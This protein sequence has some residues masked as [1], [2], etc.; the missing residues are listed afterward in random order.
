[1]LFNLEEDHGTHIRCYLIPDAGGATPAIRLCSGGHALATVNADTIR[2][3]IIAS[4]RHATGLCGFII[5]EATVPGLAGFADLELRE[6]ETGLLVY[7]RPQP[8]FHRD[9]KVF[10]LETHL[11]P[12]RRFD[13]TL[14]NTFQ[15][16]YA[17]IDRRG[18]ETSMQTFMLANCP[19]LY[20]SGR[21]QFRA[22][23]VHLHAFTSLVMMRDPFNEL[24]ERLL[25]LQHLP[26]DGADL[27][28][29]RDLLTFK[30]TIDYLRHF[31][32]LDARF[33]KQFVRRA[34]DSVLKPLSNP[35]MRQLSSS[36]ADELP[37]KNAMSATLQ[38]LSCFDVVGIREE[39]QLFAHAVEACLE[40]DRAPP[41][42]AEHAKVAEL[43]DL[44]RR[45]GKAE[46]LLEHDLEV[47]SHV[48]GA[49]AS[50]AV[51]AVPL[52]SRA[53]ETP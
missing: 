2:P 19:S 47:F 42:L 34:P 45:F 12:L 4:G 51:A 6:A 27:V 25:V 44:L 14:Q 11:L 31:E 23:E 3:E 43:G 5:A 41:V 46:L 17:G 36:D 33:C 29:A 40:L 49:F 1:M 22:I 48:K 32:R 16:W 18:L 37:K 26:R 10:R 30:A 7:R 13:D 8:A 52:P 39:P 50:A 24:A 9:A 38:A 15:G 53:G 21:L 35:I 28:G 20:V